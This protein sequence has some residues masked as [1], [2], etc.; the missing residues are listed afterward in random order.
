M[1]GDDEGVVVVPL[2]MA[3]DIAAEGREMTAY[4]DFVME[5]VQ[6]GDSIVGLYPGTKEETQVAF[7]AW[8]EAN[9][10]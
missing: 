4:E 10:R 6:A 2:E 9:S 5:R 3:D 8:R 1:V 7:K